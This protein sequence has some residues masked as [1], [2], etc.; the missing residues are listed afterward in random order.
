MELTPFHPRRRRWFVLAAVLAVVLAGFVLVWFQP[1]KLWIDERASEPVPEAETEAEGSDVSDGGPMVRSADST[2]PQ[3]VAAGGFISREHHTAGT[4]RVLTLSDGR[5]FVRLEGLDT[6]NGPD[7]YVYL[8]SNRA[9]GPEDAFDDEYVSLGRLKANQGDQN[10]ELPAD[11]NIDRLATVVIW[12]D[13]FDAVFGAA[14]L[15]SA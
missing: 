11:T 5:R 7:L 12:C 1:Q 8:S 14:D 9:D 10:Y 4:A 13:R 15:V 6:S 2:E 3:E